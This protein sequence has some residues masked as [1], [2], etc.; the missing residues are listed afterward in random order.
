MES[1]SQGNPCIQRDLM[2]MMIYIYIYIYIN[3]FLGPKREKNKYFKVNRS[4]KGF[5]FFQLIFFFFF[6]FVKKH[7]THSW[8]K[9]KKKKKNRRNTCSKSITENLIRTVATI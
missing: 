8:K 1:E 2:M 7:K 3:I 4:T 6:F 5:I 9:K